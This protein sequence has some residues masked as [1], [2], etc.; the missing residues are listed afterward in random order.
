MGSVQS[1]VG[2]IQQGIKQDS[3]EEI[4]LALSSLDELIRVVKSSNQKPNKWQQISYTLHQA[5]FKDAYK[6]FLQKKAHDTEAEAFLTE[7]SKLQYEWQR[8]VN[9]SA[10]SYSNSS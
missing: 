10:Y 2:E 4:R 7:Y 1:I 6:Q 5:K 9:P 3:A 8:I